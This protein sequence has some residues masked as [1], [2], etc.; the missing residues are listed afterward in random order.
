M[1]GICLKVIPACQAASCLAPG[2]L[3]Q[4]DRHCVSATTTL[5][6]S[7]HCSEV[8]DSVKCDLLVHQS[9]KEFNVT[10]PPGW[11]Q[12][13]SQRRCVF[14]LL[15]WFSRSQLQ[16]F[17]RNRLPTSVW[18]MDRSLS[19]SSVS[20]VHMQLYERQEGEPRGPSPLSGLLGSSTAQGLA[21]SLAFASRTCQVY[22]KSH[23]H[24]RG[25]HALQGGGTEVVLSVLFTRKLRLSVGVTYPVY[26]ATRSELK[27]PPS[28][29]KSL[30]DSGRW[31][32]WGPWSPPNPGVIQLLGKEYSKL[33]LLVLSSPATDPHC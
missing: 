17:C 30:V 7:L 29:P 6:S 1:Q 24:L 9:L 14:C 27:L 25:N 22:L 15:C 33:S 16:V 26:R 8:Q 18:R 2:P 20:Q 12:G 32:Y 3:T 23:L 21:L 19:W 5:V 31:S 13:G 4:S 11:V 10:S 28:L